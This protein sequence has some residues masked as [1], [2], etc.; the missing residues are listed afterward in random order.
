MHCFVWREGK[1]GGR[2]GAGGVV[3]RMGVQEGGGAA[4]RLRAGC[5]ESVARARRYT[6]E[7]GERCCKF[8]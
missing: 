1:G 8:G 6:R 5:I 3:V 7:S 2:K 4:R